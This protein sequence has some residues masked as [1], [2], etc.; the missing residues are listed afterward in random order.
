MPQP[1][2]LW[3]PHLLEPLL[4][5]ARGELPGNVALMRLVTAAQDQ[6]E[7]EAALCRAMEAFRGDAAAAERLAEAWRLWRDSP[8]VWP[9][10]RAI[11]DAVEAAADGTIGRWAA[12]FDRAVAVSPE[13]SV[14]LYSL[15]R[16]DLLDHGTAEVVDL[17]VT[18]DLVAP[19]RRL[20]EI[21]CGIGRFLEPLA[22]RGALVVGIDISAGMLAEAGRRRCRGLTGVL[23][24]RTAGTGLACIRD[25][26]LDAVY[27]VDSFPYLVDAGEEI[28]AAHIRDA[29]RVL[30]P[31]GTL[32]VLN[33]SYRG[34]RARD[35]ADAER[36]AAAAG[37]SIVD[38]DGGGLRYWDGQVY[39]LDKP[40]PQPRSAEC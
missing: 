40:G 25:D 13:A 17:M 1:D 30:R 6:R 11:L 39:R 29:Q 8:A 2:A 33:W 23:P 10:L 7:L 26:S 16:A 19:G 28:V 31:G 4:A 14:A 37:L 32:L 22:R 5:C 9:T 34:D 38:N 21:G 24:V 3:P 20:L 18:W 12:A 15:G 27:A 36:L 35:R